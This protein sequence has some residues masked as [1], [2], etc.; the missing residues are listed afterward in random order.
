[1]MLTILH[2]GYSQGAESQGAYYYAGRAVALRSGHAQFW[3][4]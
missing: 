3:N 4:G 2:H 1:M